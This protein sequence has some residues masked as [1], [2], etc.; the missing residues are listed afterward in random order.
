MTSEVYVHAGLFEVMCTVS[1]AYGVSRE[2]LLYVTAL[3]PHEVEDPDASIPGSVVLDATRFMLERTG[4]MALGLRFAEANDLRVQGFWGYAFI[5]CLTLRQA[6]ELLLRLQRVRSSAAQLTLQIDEDWVTLERPQD[7]PADLETVFGDAFVASFCLHRQRWIAQANSELRVSLM[8]PEKPHHRELR[9][10]VRGPVVFD[11]PKNRI[12]FP[13][14]ELDLPS[15][16]A[17]PHLA[18]LAQRQLEHRLAAVGV[19]ALHD[20]GGR[21]RRELAQRLAEG[22]SIERTAKSLSLSVRTL[23]RRLEQHGLSFQR[24][25]EEVRQTRASEYLS[26]SDESVEHIAERLG[27]ADPSNFRRAFRRWTGL[28]PSRFRAKTQLASGTD[29]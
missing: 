29:R 9:A 28:T 26:H 20:L 21:V 10:M 1:A 15:R 12:Q 13:A 19:E 2:E 4:D 24:L 14:R 25:L 6:A 8:Y 7:Q 16:G 17:D 23:R 18:K 27:Y 3:E 11:A 5:S 22:V